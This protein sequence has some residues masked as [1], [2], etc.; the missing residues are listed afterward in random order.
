MCIYVNGVYP[1]WLK[2]TSGHEL[3]IAYCKFKCYFI[4]RVRWPGQIFFFW[5]RFR[6][7]NFVST[8]F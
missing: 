2:T 6:L 5:T 1:V 7:R 3:K 4:I 8:N